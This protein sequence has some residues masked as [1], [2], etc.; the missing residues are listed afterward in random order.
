MVSTVKEVVLPGSTNMS[1]PG[2][3][4][5][6]AESP[7]YMCRPMGLAMADTVGLAVADTAGLAVVE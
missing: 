3:R 6:L 7:A 4:V 1:D 2:S 5:R